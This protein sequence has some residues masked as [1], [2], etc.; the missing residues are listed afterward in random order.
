[1]ARP[2]ITILIAL[3]LSLLL[4]VV[5]VNQRQKTQYLEG[6]KGEKTG[7]FMVA[8]TGY[9]SAIRMYLPFSSRVETAA[10]RIWALGETAEQRGDLD[11]ALAAY[12]SLRSAFYGTRWL[13]Q[14]GTDWISR[15]DKKIA[16]LVPL[17]KGNQP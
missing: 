13:Q 16:A 11:Q 14:P 5:N 12:R 9:E 2:L 8:L 1:M 6:V 17:R 3:L 15:C 4:L 7:N 10:A